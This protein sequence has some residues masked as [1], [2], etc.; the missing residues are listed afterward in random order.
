MGIAISF[1]RNRDKEVKDGIRYGRSRRLFTT[2]LSLATN[3]N[4]FTSGPFLAGWVTYL[5]GSDALNGIIAAVPSLA[6]PIQLLSA[7][8]FGSLKRRKLAVIIFAS[9]IKLFSAMIFLL[10]LVLFDTKLALPSMIFLYIM[11]HVLTNFSGPGGTNW[12]V[13]LVP[14]QMRSKYFANREAISL[15]V[16]AIAMLIV[17]RAVDVITASSGRK[18]AFLFIACVIL[19]HTVINIVILI[20]A[21][22]PKTKQAQLIE[23]QTTQIEPTNPKHTPDTPKP[24]K[25]KT[26]I[27]LWEPF[28]HKAFVQ[29]FYMMLLWNIGASFAGPFSSV[30]QVKTLSLSF[31]YITVLSVISMVCRVFLIPLAG[32]LA[33]RK[34]YYF[35]CYWSIVLIAIHYVLWAFTIK[36][37]AWIL[38][39]ILFVESAV[40]FAGINFSMF[41]IQIAAMPEEIRT[42]CLSVMNALTGILGFGCTFIAS[43]LVN[44]MGDITVKIIGFPFSS[45][46]ILFFIAAV[47]L[48]A[49][50]AYTIKLSKL[51]KRSRL[52]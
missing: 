33:S 25:N 23:E 35:V 44:Q 16:G 2:D 21:D 40:G 13:D 27:K 46:Q 52:S 49:C 1:W 45:L 30:Y 37:N 14:H 24:V 12:I 19:V 8:F 38:L 6:T 34:G 26:Q 31:T 28:R 50:A 51:H 11:I 15:A 20:L 18:S 48:F 17:G 47:L 42:T 43:I 9:I 41:N 5:G 22:E 32:K 10:P 7:F 4:T 3:I 36:E 29:V 39:P